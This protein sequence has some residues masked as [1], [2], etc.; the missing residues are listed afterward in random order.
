LFGLLLEFRGHSAFSA[1]SSLVFVYFEKE[2]LY[3]YFNFIFLKDAP[4][5]CCKRSNQHLL[6]GVML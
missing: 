3:F 2:F 1:A 4:K 6:E 5:L